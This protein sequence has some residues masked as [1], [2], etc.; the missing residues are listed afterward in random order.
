MLTPFC[1]FSS[2]EPARLCLQAHPHF[3]FHSLRQPDA[4]SRHAINTL[5]Q[6]RVTGCLRASPAFSCLHIIDFCTEPPDY[7]IQ[8][9]LLQLETP[10]RPG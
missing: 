1:S 4:R 10:H 2:T 3:S 7:G 5:S 6:T 8:G 9:M